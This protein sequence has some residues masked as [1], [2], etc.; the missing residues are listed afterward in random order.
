VVFHSV[1]LGADEDLTLDFRIPSPPTISGRVLDQNK[2]P[3]S[4]MS[5]W[6]IQSEY[7][8]GSLHYSS[9]GPRT[10]G[11]D[12]GFNFESD[13]EAGRAYYLLADRPLTE[14][15]AKGEL[16]PL[17]Q[18][19]PVDAPTYYGDATSL[20]G[21]LPFVLL[22]GEHREQMEIKTRR[23]T[24]YCVDGKLEAFGKPAFLGFSI[25]EL[26]LAGTRVT[27]FKGY[28]AEDGKFRVCN[29][30]PGQYWLSPTGSQMGGGEEFA[31]T[32]SDVH[33]LRLALDTVP[34]HLELSWDG[35]PPSDLP[36][37][38]AF[39]PA[40]NANISM[41][42]QI[43]SGSEWTSP[44]GLFAVLRQPSDSRIS[45]N[46]VGQPDGATRLK[47]EVAPYDGPFG[48]EIPAGNYAVQVGVPPNAYLKEMT[49]GGVNVTN[50][51]LQL[52][53]GTNDTLRILAAH[54]GARLT[55]IVSDGGGTAVPYA[56]VLLL[57]DRATTG[58]LLAATLQQ[59]R[60]DQSGTCVSGT[61]APGKYRV[62]ALTRPIRRTPEDMDRLMLA[63]PKAT[64]VELLPKASLQVKLQPVPI[65]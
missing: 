52:L 34:V 10:T 53:P 6:V 23:A 44:D 20:E 36:T 15:E 16:V 1:N 48:S 37:S 45:V 35:T 25:Y 47:S 57:P 49:Y 60:A 24:S 31:I 54:D 3:V 43:V 2:K 27:R 5:V 14:S 46:L 28:P 4:N 40:A 9:I 42:L 18:R 30:T 13:L 39:A 11:K 22:P 17:D 58:P 12:G 61:L 51:L 65:D 8:Y 55:Y 26:P 50:E 32:R 56:T 19:E 41:E 33:H 29:L 21:A 38:P 7:R 59:V 64:E 63:L 62:V